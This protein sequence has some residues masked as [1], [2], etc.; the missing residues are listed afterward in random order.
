MSVVVPTAP[1]SVLA[2][3]I[4]KAEIDVIW[5]PPRR[6]NGIIARYDI[7][8]QPAMAVGNIM[9]S[10][11]LK[12]NFVNALQRTLTGLEENTTYF[13][14]VVAHTDFSSGQMSS[15]KE[16]KTFG[17]EGIVYCHT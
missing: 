4:S 13:I 14:T 1:S 10:V 5:Q 2:T 7:L 6:P 8:Y 3:A 17:P 12:G 11:T 9:F 16:Q 15:L